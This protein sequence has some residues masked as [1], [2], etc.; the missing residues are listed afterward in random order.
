VTVTL[1]YNITANKKIGT[2]VIN[3]LLG[4]TRTIIFVWNTAGVEYCHNYTITSVASIAFPDAD[5]T[6]NTLADGKV[7]VRIIGDINGDGIVDMADISMQVDAFL[8]ETG[9]PR[10]NSD[11]DLD[12]DHMI[13]MADIAM[14]IDH[15]LDECP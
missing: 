13:D 3:L 8:A 5:P 11:A 10:W 12:L 15:F 7:K 4:E 1:Y 14:T 6:D 2:Q 9:H